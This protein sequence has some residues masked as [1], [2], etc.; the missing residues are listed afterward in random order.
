[1]N[2]QGLEEPV[3]KSSISKSQGTLSFVKSIRTKALW[4][5]WGTLFTERN[6]VVMN[7]P[8]ANILK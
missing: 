1:M 7:T 4:N 2:L 8:S 6:G 5:E 3:I